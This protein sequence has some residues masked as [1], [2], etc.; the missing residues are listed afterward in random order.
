MYKII[1]GFVLIGCVSELCAQDIAMNQLGYTPKGH[2]QAVVQNAKEHHFFYITSQETGKT[3]YKE[4]LTESKVWAVSG[5]EIKIADFSEFKKTGKYELSVFGKEKVAFE[6]RKDSYRAVLRASIKAY[7][8]NRASVDIEERY[9]GV[10]ARKGGHPDDFV[11]VHSSAVSDKRPEN[12]VLNSP[13]GWYDAGDYNKYIV[14]SGISTFTLLRAY[15]RFCDLHKELDLNIPESN[16][17]QADLLD[18]I[19]YNISWMVTMQDPN[20]GGVYHKLTDKRFS[21]FK[22]PTKTVTPRY[23]VQK[24]TSAALDFAA[25]LTYYSTLINDESRSKVML[26]KA[27]LAYKWAEKNPKVYYEQPEDI[28]TGK[29][30]DTDLSDEFFWAKAQL[31]I[32]T[33][34]PKYETLTDVS[35]NAEPNWKSVKAL[36]VYSLASSKTIYKQKAKEALLKCAD[37]MVYSKSKSPNGTVMGW[38]KGDFNWGSNGNAANQSMLLI[39]A[40]LI[41]KKQ[42]YKDAALSNL[43]YILGQ[44][45]TGYCYVTGFGTKSP[46]H[47]HHRLSESDGVE[48]PQPGLLSGGP[49]E[50]QQDKKQGI[51]YKSSLPALSYT[52]ELESYASN[53]IAINWNSPLVYLLSFACIK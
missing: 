32:A 16:N 4:K 9:A 53:E 48:A 36:G 33:K 11:L 28:K 15:D 46:M 1:L 3:V 14:N 13:G 8:L 23:V 44:N 39:E 34:D 51:T 38:S 31:L 50:K 22:I 25:V 37:K 42:A 47:I 18:E 5:Q 27:I 24:T 26:A 20:D 19:E 49:N 17:D 2:K 40:Y 41:S 12:T 52:D 45:P 6:I 7:Y 10:Y 30:D 21:G 29:Y 35:I 43:N